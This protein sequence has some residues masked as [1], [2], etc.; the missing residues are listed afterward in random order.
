VVDEVAVERLGDEVAGLRLHPGRAERRQVEP[1]VAVHDELVADEGGG[2]VGRHRAV[3]QVQAGDAARGD[4]V[5]VEGV[6]VQGLVPAFRFHFA[7]HGRLLRGGG[8]E[9]VSPASETPP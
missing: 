4:D 5:V 3:R 6:D 1:G 2:R 7:R 9:I 8:R